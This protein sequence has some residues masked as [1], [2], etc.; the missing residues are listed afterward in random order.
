V[1]GVLLIISNFSAE[2]ES[3]R[4]APRL[5]AISEELNSESTTVPE[6]ENTLDGFVKGFNKATGTSR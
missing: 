6:A 3:R 4:M 1:L 2:R 5:N